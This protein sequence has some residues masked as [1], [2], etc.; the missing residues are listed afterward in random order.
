[1]IIF[2]AMLATKVQR[3]ITNRSHTFSPVDIMANMSSKKV[4]PNDSITTA[5]AS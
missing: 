5:I 3:S 4:E 1:M 2:S